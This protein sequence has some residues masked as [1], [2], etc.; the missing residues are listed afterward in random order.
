MDTSFPPEFVAVVSPCSPVST[1][2][3]IGR[4]VVLTVRDPLH[5]FQKPAAEEIACYLEGA[6]LVAD[7]QMFQTYSGSYRGASVSVC[8]GGSGAPELELAMVDF[9]RW[10]SAD[11]FL[12]V[13]TCGAL[14]RS[15]GMGDIV[16]SSAAVRD[17]GT[18]QEYVKSTYP[19]V[20][21]YE[22]VLALVTAAERIGCAH[23]VGITRSND[24]IYV[25]DGRPAIEYLQE[26]H[27]GIPRYW[28]AAGV[29]NVERET[30]LLLTLANLFGKRG[31]SV[32]TVVDNDLTGSVV[33][34][35]AG[36]KESIM[37][38]LEAFATLAEWD[39]RKDTLGRRYLSEES[40][41]GNR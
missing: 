30:S 3:D 25:G 35:G 1:A 32:C 31:G 39:R 29:L 19:A 8:A 16:I 18:S 24:A 14:Q 6:H 41:R 4:Y 15:I 20:A 13:G 36:K 11:T 5:D 12:R 33:D 40:V 7:T 28:E 10:T 2:G 26:E 22:V 21:S 37:V 9:L 34:V 27:K 38:A 17:E 23:H